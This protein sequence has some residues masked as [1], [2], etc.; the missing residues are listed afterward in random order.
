MRR[1]IYQLQVASILPEVHDAPGVIRAVQVLAAKFPKAMRWLLD[2]QANLVTLFQATD[3]GIV[4]MGIAVPVPE[5]TERNKGIRWVLQKCVPSA[6]IRSCCTGKTYHLFK[7]SNPTCYR[8]V[9]LLASFYSSLV[10]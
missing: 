4:A 6:A 2:R 7:S 5:K 3:D 8:K 1:L 10:R 9:Y